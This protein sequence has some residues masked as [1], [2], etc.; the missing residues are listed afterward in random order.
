MR[1]AFVDAPLFLTLS[2][3][4]V[5]QTVLLAG[6]KS[7]LACVC[8]FEPGK[9][10]EKQIKAAI[11]REFNEAASVFSGE[12]I[13]LDTFIV[14]FKLITMWKGDALEEF[15]IST[16]AK[17]I[18][19]DSYRRSSC[20]SNFKT[21]EKYLVYARVNDDNQIGCAILYT[22]ECAVQWAGGYSRAGYPEFGCLSRTI[23]SACPGR[24]FSVPAKS[25]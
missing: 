2:I 21:G 23:T 1:R 16:G 19:E 20:D 22:Y 15:T 7:A 10:S 4:A 11:A 13:A 5:G 12:V 14:K 17:K 24:E 6:S 18:S 9:R 3:C 8:V 25:N